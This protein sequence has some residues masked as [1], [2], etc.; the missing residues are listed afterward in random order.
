MLVVHI[1]TQ[2]KKKPVV[3]CHNK[4]FWYLVAPLHSSGQ[5][6]V[7]NTDNLFFK[8]KEFVKWVLDNTILTEQTLYGG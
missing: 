4:L 1:S 6:V 5:M 8:E 3:G 2:N 7:K